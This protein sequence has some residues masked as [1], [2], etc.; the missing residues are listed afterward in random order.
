MKNTVEGMNSKLGDIEEH[1]RN[2]GDKIMEIPPSQ[3]QK[4][5]EIFKKSVTSLKNLWD[6]QVYQHLHYGGHRRR[7]ERRWLKIC[8][9]KLCL[10]TSYAW[11]WKYIPV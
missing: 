5:K 9:M 11:R 7:T 8:L 2:L 3:K 6:H 1:K 10:K 4:E